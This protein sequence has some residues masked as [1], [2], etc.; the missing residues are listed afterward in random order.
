MTEPPWVANQLHR[1]R[2]CFSWCMQ[3]VSWGAQLWLTEKKT[4]FP[5][6]CYRWSTWSQ[7]S[8]L[9]LLWG[10]SLITGTDL[11]LRAWR[12]KM[13][14]VYLLSGF[15]IT[16][17]GDG[18]TAPRWKHSWSHDSTTRLIWPGAGTWFGIL[19][20][21]TFFAWRGKSIGKSIEKCHIDF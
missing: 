18:K 2:D 5:L 14:G 6:L 12:K 7:R 9:F 4:L 19:Y 21:K 10:E 1:A 20:T 8:H 13:G 17:A 16:P 15:A 3:R 11:T